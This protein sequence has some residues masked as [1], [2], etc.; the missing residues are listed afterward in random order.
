MNK[1]QTQYIMATRRNL[2][3]SKRGTR[4]K[5]QKGGMF[6]SL[7]SIFGFSGQ[8]QEQ[9]QGGKGQEQGQEQKQGQG[10]GQGQ[11]QGQQGGKRRR[12]KKGKSK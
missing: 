1:M 6:G 2:N 12:K 11:E 9:E 10:Q 8:E 5:K 7:A 4:G 3:K